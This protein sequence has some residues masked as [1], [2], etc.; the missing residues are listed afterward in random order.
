VRELVE[1]YKGYDVVILGVTS[2]Q[3]NS[4]VWEGGKPKDRIDTKGNTEK[5]YELMGAFMKD[6][7]MTWPVVFSE[8]AV[9]N[10]EYGVNGIP[11]VA[12]IDTNGK[13]RFRGLHPANPLPQKADKIDSLLKEAG[14]KVPPPATKEGEQVDDK[15]DKT[16]K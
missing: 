6:M 5:E 7:D 3:G 11:H 14:L 12:I 2:V 4:V 16:G 15:N 1:R 8:E 10:P 9:F 13:L